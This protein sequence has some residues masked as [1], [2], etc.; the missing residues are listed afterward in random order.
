MGQSIVS[1]STFTC[2]I[3]GETLV[4]SSYPTGWKHI[5]ITSRDNLGNEIS[6]SYDFSP[7][8]MALVDNETL[9]K[10]KAF[11]I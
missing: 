10:L 3:T 2:D 8:G 9:L 4:Q 7:D 11:I 6:V 5:V 1:T